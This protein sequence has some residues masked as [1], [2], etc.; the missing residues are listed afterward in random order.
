VTY[1][2]LY[3]YDTIGIDLAGIYLA[4]LMLTVTLLD[5][6]TGSLS[7]WIGQKGVLMLTFI[8]HS[9]GI[10]LFVF[11]SSLPQFIL[12][13]LIFGFS[14]A[15]L[16]GT[17]D[18]WFDNNYSQIVEQYDP[19]KTT[20]KFFQARIR[21]IITIGWLFGVI[22][23]G[24]LASSA[25][26]DVGFI[27][28][29]IFSLTFIFLVYFLMNDLKTIKDQKTENKT[30][31]IIIKSSLKFVISSRRI[32][33]LIGGFA[34]TQLGFILWA[35]ILLFKVYFGYT[36][37]DL[38]ASTIRSFVGLI[39]IAIFVILLGNISKNIKN[40]WDFRHLTLL[41]IS[42]FFGGFSL[43]F[44]FF[45][46]EDS[47]NFIGIVGTILVFIFST[48]LLNNLNA[49]LYQQLMLELVPSEYRNSIYSL[50]SSLSYLLGVIIIPITSFT[51][52]LY[53]YFVALL[54]MSITS[55]F[56]LFFIYIAFHTEVEYPKVNNLETS[57]E[58]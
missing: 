39:A 44:I 3:V 43:L 40:A 29:S 22:F 13:A 34:I 1:Q 49:I 23:G 41:Q 51:F 50:R 15:Q 5:Y 25:S 4:V 2:I 31:F 47:F 24:F 19:N 28:E 56:G 6:P 8:T 38:G 45:P 57:I 32:T 21:P 26:R 12:I 30:F 11:A 52:F 18:T 9:L 58:T 20:F 55:F 48:T 37:S 27:F 14:R 53:G 42:L 17:I 46:P 7:D 35:E 16:S 10:L 33:F 54:I 36:G